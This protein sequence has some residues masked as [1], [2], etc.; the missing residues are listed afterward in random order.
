[1]TRTI[2]NPNTQGPFGN[3]LLHSAVA[4]GDL[5]EVE[6]LLAAGAD[7]TIRNRE[8]RTARHAAAILGHHQ[9]YGLLAG[10]ENDRLDRLLDQALEATFPASDPIAVSPEPGAR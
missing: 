5:R 3:T 9:I 8:G 6:R 10:P 7:P 1:M 4:S 2:G